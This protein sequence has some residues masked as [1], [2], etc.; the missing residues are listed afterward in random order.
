METIALNCLFFEKNAFLYMH[1]GDTQTERRTNSWTEP[2][3]KG[4]RSRCR[5]RRLKNFRYT[6]F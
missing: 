6:D 3:R 2:M 1:F 4:A 5:E